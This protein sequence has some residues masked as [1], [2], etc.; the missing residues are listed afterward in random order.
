MYRVPVLAL[1]CAA[2]HEAPG[3]GMASSRLLLF[4]VFLLPLG[5]F[6]LAGC[7]TPEI[8]PSNNGRPPSLRL[9][10]ENFSG[11]AVNPS[12]VNAPNT[13]PTTT[14]SVSAQAGTQLTLTGSA[15]DNIGGVK[16]LEVTVLDLQ[17]SGT[18]T[19]YDL[20]GTTEPNAEGQVPTTLGF[21]G[22]DGSHFGGAT[23]VQFT[24][25]TGHSYQ[26]VMTAA[27]YNG[28][29]NT[30]TAD[31]VLTGAPPSGPPTLPPPSGW[32]GSVKVCDYGGPATLSLKASLTTP[33][34]TGEMGTLT[35]NETDV[36]NFVASPDGSATSSFRTMQTYAQGTW[37]IT[38]AT[39]VNS[40]MK[41]ITGSIMLITELPGSLGNPVLDFTHGTCVQ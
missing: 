37:Q 9:A 29:I 5:L 11:G 35:M 19:L 31:V 22:A 38:S 12:S 33:A 14:E 25:T 30:L 41:T 17:S 34:A 20:S 4:G 10:L 8:V 27:N 24:A 26:I 1:A 15:T 2:H 16:S 32:L 23:A 6:L 7:Q 36:L 21:L 18:T 39:V 13:Q 28:E 3:T 40:S